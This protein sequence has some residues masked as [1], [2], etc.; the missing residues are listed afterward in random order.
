MVAMDV[1]ASTSFINENTFAAADAIAMMY[2]VFTSRYTTR[3]LQDIRVCEYTCKQKTAESSQADCE[4][5]L[6]SCTSMSPYAKLGAVSPVL[7]HKQFH[8]GISELVFLH[9]RPVWMDVQDQV[10]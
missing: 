3:Y 5:Y 8:Q 2:T 6:L 10:C 9:S 7:H 1:R 4:S